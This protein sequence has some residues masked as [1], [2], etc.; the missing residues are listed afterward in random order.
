[1]E[2][3]HK[4]NTKHAASIGFDLFI[5]PSMRDTAEY[6]ANKM[7]QEQ[8]FPALHAGYEFIFWKLSIR[9]QAGVHLSS[10]GRK[11]KGN[12]FIRP[13]V[14]YEFNKH[15]FAQLGLKTM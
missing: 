14:R 5:D 4:F 7:A 8:V 1:M 3:Q 13:S 2:Y 12:T 10:M 15:L 9:M 11:L 6:P